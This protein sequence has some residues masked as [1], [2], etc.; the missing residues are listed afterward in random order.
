MVIDNTFVATL[1]AWGLTVGF[2]SRAS[3]EMVEVPLVVGTPETTPD[4]LNLSPL[5]T[6]VP[7]TTFQRYGGLPPDA[8]SLVKYS[9]PTVAPGRAEVVIANGMDA[10]AITGD[11]GFVV[12]PVSVMPLCSLSLG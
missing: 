3:K 6:D 8:V 12:G 4:V 7:L 11:M 1:R 2:A 9:W 10:L 5:G